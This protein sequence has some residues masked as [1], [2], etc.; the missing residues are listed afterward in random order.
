MFN[1]TFF[2]NTLSF[3]SILAVGFVVLFLA[4]YF[5]QKAGSD[6]LDDVEVY[7]DCITDTGEAC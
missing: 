4:E 5:L 1:R 7:S 6:S 3:I 2:K